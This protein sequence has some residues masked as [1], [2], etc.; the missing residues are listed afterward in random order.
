M[1]KLLFIFF[2]FLVVFVFG[3]LWIYVFKTAGEKA[4][5]NGQLD[6]R[7]S[8]LSDGEYNGKYS[9]CYGLIQSDVY[10]KI[11]KGQLVICKFKR[12][13]GTPKYGAPEAIIKHINKTKSFD[14]DAV[15]GATI[16]KNIAI[17]GIK[18]AIERKGKNK[19]YVELK[20]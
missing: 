14:L 4:A 10:F 12:L 20:K 16:T 15:T 9:Y 8:D 17:A 6:V 5:N 2:F 18:N 7:I 11:T 19:L 13:T 1:K 3:T